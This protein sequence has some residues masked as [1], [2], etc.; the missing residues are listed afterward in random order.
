MRVDDLDMNELLQFDEGRIEMGGRRLVL[1]S[2]DAFAVYRKDLIDSVGLALARTILTR[3][4]YFWG[5]ADAA[6]MQRMFTWES[7]LELLKA[8][9]RI[10]TLQG[11]VRAQ[12]KKIEIDEK[13][14]SFTMELNWYESGEAREHL[15]QF[16]ASDHQVCWTLAGYASGYASHCLHSDIY[17]TEERCLAKGDALCTATG[18]DAAS[19]GAQLEEVSRYFRQGDI[20]QQV[21]GLTAE[22]RRTAEELAARRRELFRYRARQEKGFAETRS[23]TFQRV[24]EV[25]ERVARYDTTVLITGETGTG[26][27]LVAEHIHLMS[28]RSDR[29]M[30]SVNCGALPETLLDSEL[31][32]HRSGAFTGAIE[33]HIGL[34]ERADNATI[35]LDEIGEISQSLQVKLLRVLQ[36]GELMRVGESVARRVD[37]RVIAATNRNLTEAIEQGR[38]RADLFY[39]LG[40]VQI[41]VPALRD[42]VEDILP[43][44][45]LLLERI[46]ERLGIPGLRLEAKCLDHLTAYG[47]PGN[48]R[49]LENVLERAAVLSNEGTI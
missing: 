32:G 47:W 1:H 42:R 16:G 4:G 33:D 25:A 31:F 41:E 9:P 35:F 44:S 2:L 20:E 10:H 6:A 28:K 40:V 43:L 5:Q 8:G 34:F 19:W 22:L 39:R 37:A 27:E 21:A 23:P 26:K 29:P 15:L 7:E 45:R 24:L 36:T 49:E 11:V 3:F 18:R 38:F 17:F 12:V 46:S 13:S 30:T 48:V 14:G